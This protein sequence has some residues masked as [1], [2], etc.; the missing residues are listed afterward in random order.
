MKY[1][2]SRQNRWIDGEHVVEIAAGGLD[3]SGAD[4][5][6]AYWGNLGEGAEY[7]D[8]REAITVA[9]A[10]RDA[11]NEALAE[12]CTE[13]RCRIEAGYNLDMI[14]ANEEPTDANLHEW[15]REEWE[16]EPKCDRCG[17]PGDLDWRLVY[18]DFDGEDGPR[19]CSEHCAG[20]YWEKWL[21]DQPETE[22]DFGVQ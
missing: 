19:F 4:M 5:L 17:E 6:Q 13:E 3:H 14:A 20:A 2:V 9:I 8:P 18:F 16:A 1:F 10:I 15:A 7:D 22:P 12:T 21:E 11:W